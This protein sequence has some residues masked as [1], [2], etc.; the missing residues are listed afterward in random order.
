MI[1][2]QSVNRAVQN[3]RPQ[4]FY[5]FTAAERRIAFCIGPSLPQNRFVK[6][7]IMWAGLNRDVYTFELCLFQEGSSLSNR[8]VAN[9]QPCPCFTGKQYRTGNRFLLYPPGTCVIVHGKIFTVNGRHFFAAKICYFCIFSMHADQTVKCCRLAHPLHQIPIC[10]LR[11]IRVGKTHKALVGYTTKTV[12]FFHILNAVWCQTTPESKIHTGFLLRHIKFQLE[13]L[14]VNHR[15]NAQWHINN[16]C[17]A[18]GCRALGSTGPIFAVIERRGIPH[19]YMCI[20]SARHQCFPV[21][22]HFRETRQFRTGFKN[23]CDFT[24]LNS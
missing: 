1:R 15:G 16:C 10:N 7:Q 23:S 22:I 13:T 8:H 9:I 20:N 18:T 4:L 21:N 6:Q 19:M 2:T 5:I 17:N 12:Q 24:I 3:I 11:V 14:F